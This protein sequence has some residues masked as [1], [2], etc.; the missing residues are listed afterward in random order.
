[1]CE[2]ALFALRQHR[3]PEPN[4]MQFGPSA[5]HMGGKEH[6]QKGDFAANVGAKLGILSSWAAGS[7]E[8]TILLAPGAPTSEGHCKMKA[9]VL[10]SKCHWPA[11]RKSQI[12]SLKYHLRRKNM[13]SSLVNYLV[14]FKSL[15]SP[16]I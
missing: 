3:R 4:H 7:L 15:G 16:E 9:R 11:V 10:H 12:S 5:S 2:H 13:F 6:T 14:K 1:M 8:C